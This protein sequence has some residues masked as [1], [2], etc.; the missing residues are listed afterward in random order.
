MS[1]EVW[2][3]VAEL[4]VANRRLTTENRNLAAKLSD[5]EARLERLEMM[6]QA[7]NFKPTVISTDVIKRAVA[8]AQCATQAAQKDDGKYGP[9]QPRKA[10]EENPQ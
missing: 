8:N 3:T 10:A 1:E 7:I 5:I 9:I 6:H 2:D 4:I